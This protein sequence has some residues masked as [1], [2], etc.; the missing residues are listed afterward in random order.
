MTSMLDGKLKMPEEQP[1]RNICPHLDC[2]CL[3][4]II[5]PFPQKLHQGRTWSVVKVARNNR[6][7]ACI[8][9]NQQKAFSDP[10]ASSRQELV[11]I[12][13]KAIR[14]MCY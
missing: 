3:E 14:M 6:K 11:K 5:K 8:L 12:D 4:E 9:S 13:T 7:H 10:L 1:A 2:V